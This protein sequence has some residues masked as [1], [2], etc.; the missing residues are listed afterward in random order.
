[1]I[2]FPV[3]RHNYDFSSSLS[4]KPNKTFGIAVRTVMTNRPRANPTLT[5]IYKD[6]NNNSR[7]YFPIVF[8]RVVN[9]VGTG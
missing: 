2:C 8:T 3:T 5:T 6:N 7:N 9:R 4:N 1:M